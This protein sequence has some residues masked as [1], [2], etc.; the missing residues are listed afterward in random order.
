M[1]P[2]PP[3]GS[4]K[5]D[6]DTP[7]LC[8]DLEVMEANI[9]AVAAT[10][11]EAN[12]AWRPH[13][14]GHKNTWIAR[15]ELAAGAI[16]ITCAK[17]GEAEVMAAGG[18]DDLLIANQVV[19]RHKLPRLVELRRR[20][21]PIICV[22]HLEQARPASDAMSAAG[23]RLR[24]LIEIDLGLNRAGTAPGEPTV[25][26]ARQIVRLPGL[27]LAGVMGYEGHL[28]TV[29]DAAEKSARIAAALASLVDC[30]RLI[31]ASGMPCPIVS[32]G[33][34]GSYVIATR[35][36]GITEVQAGGAIFMDAFY[37]HAC[38]LNGLGNA[39]TILTT[40][41]GRPAADRAII[42]AGRKTMNIEVHTP[43]VAGRRGVA[44]DRLSAEHGQLRLMPDA[45]PLVIGQRLELLPG[46]ADLTVMLHDRIY[47][48]RGGQLERILP[49][50]SRGMVQ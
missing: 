10:C 34:T 18:I 25:E 24:V 5:D 46:Y 23:L 35:Q 15:Q 16:G 3:L 43:Q 7:A 45:E 32:C 27:E 6:L 12:V 19:G 28:L 1:L 41:V 22:D 20:A 42:D 14:K 40:V 50:E 21:D 9:R 2:T 30:R 47:G 39:L 26:L 8:L 33:G 37:R 29:A 38:G 48:F 49:V 4:T 31:E 11:R 17:L 13:S 36:P 44:V